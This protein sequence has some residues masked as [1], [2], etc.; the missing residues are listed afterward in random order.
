MKRSREVSVDLPVSHYDRN[1][2]YGLDVR[3]PQTSP[4]ETLI[5]GV[6]LFGG[7]A[8]GRGSGFEGGALMTGASALIRDTRELTSL[9]VLHH[10]RTR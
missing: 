10:V 2:C 6:L 5:P 4:V 7:G 9:S 1:Y 3:V 8:F